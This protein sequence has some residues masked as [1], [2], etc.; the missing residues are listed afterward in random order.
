MYKYLYVAFTFQGH[1]ISSDLNCHLKYI[2]AF[3]GHPKFTPIL[4][5]EMLNSLT[6][7]QSNPEMLKI[8]Q[9]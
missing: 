6:E 5:P 2:V 9:H 1:G 7:P 4:D 8:A 3:L